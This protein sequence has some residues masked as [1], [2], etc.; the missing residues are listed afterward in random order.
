MSFTERTPLEHGFAPVF[1]NTVE[2]QLAEFE[3]ER[4]ALLRKTHRNMVLIALAGIALVGL[5]YLIW[6]NDSLPGAP[7]AGVILTAIALFI[8]PASAGDKWEGKLRDIVMPAI[9]DHVGDLTYSGGG[10]A[11]SI[12]V[13]KD[14]KLL[15]KHDRAARSH[16]YRGTRNGTDFQMVHA[17]LTI[18]TEG[19]NDQRKTTTVFQGLL[20]RIDLPHAAPGR[21]ALM[22]DR[23]SVGNKVAEALSFGS[24]RSLPKVSFDHDTFEAAFEV[25]ADQP[26]AAKDFLT[27]AKR[28]A[29]LQFGQDQGGGLGAQAFVAGYYGASFYM[30][31][32]R[33]GARMTMGGLNTSVT[34]IEEDLHRVFDAIALAHSAVDTLSGAAA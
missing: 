32:E 7:I 14:L 28:D 11:F 31:L 19:S 22:R 21:I 4:K 8:A 27:Q 25:Y 26:D 23:G 30:A 9:C 12:D 33:G 17:H 16:L 29:L 5:A 3:F 24:T 1:A 10:S 18:T 6:G 2:P 34:E 13:F 20:F 15:P